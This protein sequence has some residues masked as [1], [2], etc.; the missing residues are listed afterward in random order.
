MT[1]CFSKAEACQRCFGFAEIFGSLIPYF[2]ANA[3]GYEKLI[4]QVNYTRAT[5]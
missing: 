3:R 4:I 1:Y 5:L 2:R